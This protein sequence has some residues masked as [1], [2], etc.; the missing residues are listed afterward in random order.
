[1]MNQKATS[2]ETKEDDFLG[3]LKTKCS[4]CTPASVNVYYRNVLRLYRLIE[5]GDIPAG[6]AWLLKGDLFSKFKK[7]PLSQRRTL[8]VAAVKAGQVYGKV[9]EK[10]N[11]AMYKAQSE[12]TDQRNKNEKSE[13]EKMLW[14][15]GGFLAV[16]KAAVEQK[17]RIKHILKAE[18]NVSGLYKYQ[19][20]IVLKLF[21]E[22]PWRNGFAD[23]Q[24]QEADTGNYIKVP[25]KGHVVFH[26]RQYKNS[27]QLGER[28][29]T[30]G[31]NT[32]A[33]KKF[34]RYQ[35]L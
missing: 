16:K 35:R 20:F 7:L 9:P 18:P 13:K 33:L 21:S 29:L 8:S 17:R 25:K 5:E 3:K 26:M 23:L 31:A 1:M 34:L 2:K 28:A 10:W 4:N 6:G 22:L 19:F 30:L 27:K 14:P 32:I 15:K 11:T 24:V 12:Y